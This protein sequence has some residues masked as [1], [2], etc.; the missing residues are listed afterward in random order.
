[1]NIMNALHHSKILHN[2]FSKDNIMGVVM[3]QWAKK[4]SDYKE[5]QQKIDE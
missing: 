2:D 3:I 4:A 1:M 5:K